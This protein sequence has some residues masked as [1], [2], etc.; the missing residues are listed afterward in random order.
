MTAASRT[1]SCFTKV[2]EES[3]LAF[4][5]TKLLWS[6]SKVLCKCRGYTSEFNCRLVSLSILLLPEMV[7][8]YGDGIA[9]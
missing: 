3:S 6:P 4:V 8:I 1:D 7:L 9:P 5:P 2:S